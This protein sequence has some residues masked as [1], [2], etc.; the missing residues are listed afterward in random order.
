MKNNDDGMTV[1]WCDGWQ[2]NEVMDCL[3]MAEMTEIHCPRAG[4]GQ[5]EAIF[6]DPDPGPQSRATLSLA[7][8]LGRLDPRPGGSGQGQV[9]A[10]PG[11][12]IFSSEL[13][14]FLKMQ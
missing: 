9:R 13:I 1:W 6:A 3:E 7:L 11:P 8:A 5:V 10:D 14:F 12:L 4:L 2:G